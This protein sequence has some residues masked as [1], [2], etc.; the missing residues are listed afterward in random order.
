MKHIILSLI[1]ATT[2][3]CASNKTFTTEASW[4]GERYRGLPMANGKPFNPDKDNI[5]ASW[6]Y[7]FGTKLKLTYNKKSVIGVVQDRGPARRLYHTGRKLDLSRALFMKLIGNTEQGVAKVKV[8][9]I[10]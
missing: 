10:K 9:V 4:Y 8:E 2:V 6:D 3:A 1:M 5:I 7:P